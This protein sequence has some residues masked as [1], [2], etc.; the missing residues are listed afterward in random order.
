MRQAIFDVPTSSVA[1]VAERRGPRG[2]KRGGTSWDF[3]ELTTRFLG[4]V[5]KRRLTRGGGFLGEADCDA[6]RFAQID[7]T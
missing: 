1:I 7:R 6:V 2:F 3:I 5:R 4:L